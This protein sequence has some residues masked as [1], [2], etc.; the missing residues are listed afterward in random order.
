MTG[1]SAANNFFGLESRWLD[2]ANGERV[3][4]H[5]S[6]TGMPVL[7]VHGSAVGV[8]AAANWWK[9]FPSISTRFRCIAPDLIGYGST[10]PA[11]NNTEWG[12][13]CWVDQVVR[14]A[15]ALR[16]E[17]FALIGN[18]LGGRISLHVALENPGR[19]AGVI[20]MGTVGLAPPP[21]PAP[22]PLEQAWTR[23]DV[24][25][26]MQRMVDDTRVVT[27]ALV[28]ER[29]AAIMAPGAAEAF[30]KASLARNSTVA[31]TAL[32]KES[33]AAMQVPTLLIHGREDHVIPAASSFELASVIPNADFYLFAHCGHW[34]Q[35]ERVDDF[36]RLS[37]QFL[38]Q[39]SH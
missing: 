14:F 4:Y 24:M 34:A 29:F 39:V 15:D 36:N 18:S 11:S 23:A 16:L 10:K 1:Q 13:R 33:L 6:G 31:A 7:L 2:T 28:D 5:E 17:R 3:H 8:S 35:I 32:T 12:L 26:S 9:N 27:E 20:T 22:R 37:M 30:Y 19:V 21:Q 38:Q 25:R